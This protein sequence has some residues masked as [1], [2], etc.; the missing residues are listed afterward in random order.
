[1]TDILIALSAFSTAIATI[2]IAILTKTNTD[3]SKKTL[4]LTEATH[5]LNKTIE[6]SANQFQEDMKKLQIELAAAQLYGATNPPGKS[7][8]TERLEEHRRIIKGGL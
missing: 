3:L 4:A 2:A 6:M 7:L 5:E 8:S 1:M